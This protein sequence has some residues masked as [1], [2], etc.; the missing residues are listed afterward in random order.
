MA[1]LTASCANPLAPDTVAA[2]LAAAR[3]VRGNAH[4]PYSRFAVGAALL[5]DLGRI[6]VGCNVENA[7]YP[8]TQCAEASALGALVS[9]GG[10]RVL[11]AAV[12]AEAPGADPVTPCG[13][14]RQRLAEFADPA[15]T[16]WLAGLHGPGQ[17]RTLGEL[18]PWGFGAGH[19][20]SAPPAPDAARAE[21]AA[22]Q[23]GAPSSPVR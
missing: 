23:G 15:A 19:L 5:D 1:D 10:R 17:P 21:L 4:A 2:L 14:C 16:V 22:N 8:L 20:P 18:L 12:V 9:A 11:G 13:A 6:H 7:A 3:A